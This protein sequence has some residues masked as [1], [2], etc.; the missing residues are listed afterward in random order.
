VKVYLDLCCLSRLTDDQSQA[1]IREEAEAIERVLARVRM[2]LVDMISSEA[3]EGEARRNP[4]M[5]RRLEVEAFLSLASNTVEIDDAVARRAPHCRSRVGACGRAA[6]YRRPSDQARRAWT[7]QPSNPGAESGILEQ[8]ARTM[9]AIDELTDEQFERH[10][11]DVLKRELGADGLARFLRL[12]RSGSGDYTNDRDGW[13][14]DLTLDQILE[15]IRA[16]RR[17]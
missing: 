10:A 17:P 8:G 5:D 11:L 13:Q 2:G 1:R 4:S 15:S 14:K 12:N 16:H 6:V 7:G 3:L 9:I